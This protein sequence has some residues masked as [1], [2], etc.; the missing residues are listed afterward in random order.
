MIFLF[1]KDCVV[2][3]LTKRGHTRWD[4]A[5]ACRLLLIIDMFVYVRTHLFMLADSISK[6]ML[7][8]LSFSSMSRERAL[9]SVHEVTSFGLSGEKSDLSPPQIN[10]QQH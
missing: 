9:K 7:A 4:P 1:A 5:G 8:N 2:W 3:C 10:P 6:L